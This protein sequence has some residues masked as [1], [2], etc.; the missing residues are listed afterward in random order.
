MFRAHAGPALRVAFDKGAAGAIQGGNC[1]V[2]YGGDAGA[3]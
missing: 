3:F 2:Y 1:G